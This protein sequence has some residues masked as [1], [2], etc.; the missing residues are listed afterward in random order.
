[1]WFTARAERNSF[2]DKKFKNHEDVRQGGVGVGAEKATR[3]I[4]GI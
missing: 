2:R 4:K 1:M 3:H